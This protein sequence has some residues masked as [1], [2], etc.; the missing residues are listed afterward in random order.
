MKDLG[1]SA[2]ARPYAHFFLRVLRAFFVFFVISLGGTASAAD[3]SVNALFESLAKN[4]PGRATFTEKKFLSLLDAPVQ[5]SGELIFTPPDRMEKKT[6]KPKPESVVVQG[7]DVTLER[8]GKRHTLRLRENPA[9]AVLVESIRSTLAGDLNALTRT[10][11]VAL[12]GAPAR[13][14]LTLRP[15]DAAAAQL[16][17]RIEIGGAEARV[18]S[19]EIFQAD[20]DRSLM[21][22]APAK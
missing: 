13:W 20:G 17:E 12:D 5:S 6:L 21:A 1:S 2:L 11:S 14:R 9:I 15:L 4:Q 7:G 8:G 18:A 3:W 22:I 16:V 10:Y 19:V